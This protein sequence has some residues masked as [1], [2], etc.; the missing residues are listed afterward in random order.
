LLSASKLHAR[1]HF[2]NSP[3]DEAPTFDDKAD[4]NDNDPKDK[5]YQPPKCSNALHDEAPECIYT[6][7]EDELTSETKQG[8]ELVGT[9]QKK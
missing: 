5:S 6:G 1:G 9:P 8:H 3:S 2:V 7:D 4:D